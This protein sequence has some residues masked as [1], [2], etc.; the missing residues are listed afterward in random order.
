MLKDGEGGGEAIG[1]GKFVFGFEFGGEEGLFEIGGDDGYGKVGKFFDDMAG[2]AGAAAVPDHVIDFT[3]VHNAHR[4]R[5]SA[6][7]GKLDEA[8]DLRSARLALVNS[9]EG[10]CIENRALHR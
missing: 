5:I 4:K 10:A 7:A 2:D 6:I 9:D 3:P 1:V 8:G